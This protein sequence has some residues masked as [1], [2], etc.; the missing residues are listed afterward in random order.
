MPLTALTD[1][2]LRAGRGLKWSRAPAGV[3]PADIAELDF[4]LAPPIRAVLSSAVE[5]SDVGYPDYTGGAP[6]RLAELFAERTRR[7]MGWSPEPARVEVC[8]QVVQA[9]CCALLAFTRRGDEVLLHSPTYPPFLEAVRSLGR[10]PLLLPVRGA[11]V[12]QWAAV[13]GARRLRLVVLCHPH[14]PTGHVFGR[15]ALERL[16]GLA[17]RSDAVVFA[18]EIH[19]EIVYPGTEFHSIASVR[20]A[21]ERTIVFTSAAKSFNI[22]GLRCAVGHF[23]GAELHARFRRLPWHLRSG[24]GALGIAAT[25][26]AWESCDDWLDQLRE[27]LGTNRTRVTDFMSH[28]EQIRFVPPSGTY[29]AWLDLRATPAASDAH[30]YFAKT[31]MIFLQPGSVFGASLEG[32]V[33]MNFGTSEERL[34]SLLERF[35]RALDGSSGKG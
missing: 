24:A 2:E 28:F 29:L 11:G 23:G 13:E 34:D 15:A 27:Q 33:R 32:F 12:A 20:A 8:A 26:A 10:R 31:A 9:L 4:A 14:N 7:R 22:A 35:G 21:A 1:G 30:G 18:D 19:A 16:A 3:I 6:V 25:I 17:V 5:R